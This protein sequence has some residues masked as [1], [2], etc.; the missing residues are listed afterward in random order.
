[1]LDCVVNLLW[2]SPATS[3]YLKWG[4]AGMATA[5]EGMQA[6]LRLAH[7]W[8][9]ERRTRQAVLVSLSDLDRQSVDRTDVI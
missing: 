5:F 4:G 2:V 6:L 7:A 9:E 1:M 3:M 8:S